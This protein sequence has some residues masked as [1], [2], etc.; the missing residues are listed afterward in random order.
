MDD[1]VFWKKTVWQ[2][3]KIEA[4]GSVNGGGLTSSD[5]GRMAANSDYKAPNPSLFPL[6]FPTPSPTHT[7]K[8]IL[9]CLY[10]QT[11]SQTM[12]AS[13][14]TP[15]PTPNHHCGPF[16]WSVI[17]HTSA[18]SISLVSSSF[19]FI[20]FRFVTSE[21]PPVLCKSP[22]LHIAIKSVLLV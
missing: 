10:A 8:P 4:S 20:F 15:F 21:S 9:L 11:K 5:G 2:L 14:K 6:Q 12:I 19:L 18:R 1:P 3:F 22:S 17:V 13:S 7:S 16:W